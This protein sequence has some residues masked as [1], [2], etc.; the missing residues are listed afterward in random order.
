MNHLVLC[1]PTASTSPFSLNLSQTPLNSPVVIALGGVE[2]TFCTITQ[3]SCI[4]R[5]SLSPLI[6][7]KGLLT[8]LSPGGHQTKKLLDTRRACVWFSM[9]TG[10]CPRPGIQRWACKSLP[11]MDTGD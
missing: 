3:G 5:S 11:H 1:F 6:A 2:P 9:E 10:V 4:A 7:G 8:L